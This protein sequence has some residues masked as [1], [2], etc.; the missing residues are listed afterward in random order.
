LGRPTKKMAGLVPLRDMV[1]DVP[2][3][4]VDVVVRNGLTGKC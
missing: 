1:A 2:K 3:A 4:E